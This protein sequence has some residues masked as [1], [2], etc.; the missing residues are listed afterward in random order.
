[1]VPTGWE[2]DETLYAGSAQHYEKGRLPYP[3]GL[4][5]VLADALTLDGRGRLI[6]VGCGPGIVGLRLAHLYQ[7][8]VGIDADGDMID[9]ATRRSARLGVP[10]AQWVSMRAEDLPAQLGSFRTATF[11]QSFH[12]LDRFRV[13][14]AVLSMLEPEG[15]LVHVEGWTLAGDPAPDSRHPLPPYAAM[16]SLVDEHLG[17]VRR[18][19]RSVLPAGTPDDEA[20]VLIRAGFEGPETAT[21][22]GGEVVISTADDIIARSFSTSSSAPHLF[23]ERL[24]EFAQ[25]ARTLLKAASPSGLF[26]EQL[27]DAHLLLW[28][29]G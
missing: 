9:E 14:T 24:D 29:K 8:V 7:Q 19:G 3:A 13:A 4:A 15:C 5:N 12:W 27:R 2:W 21:V 25:D 26:A 18:A 20:S 11:A 16:K 22:P 6:D 23:G 28:R 17:P 1:M 10:N